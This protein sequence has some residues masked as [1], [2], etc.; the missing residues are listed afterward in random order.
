ML[1]EVITAS[2]ADIAF[3]SDLSYPDTPSLELDDSGDSYNFV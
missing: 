2:L 3:L 1:Y